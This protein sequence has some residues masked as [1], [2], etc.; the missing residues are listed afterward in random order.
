MI[1]ELGVDILPT[2]EVATL[3]ELAIDVDEERTIVS[4]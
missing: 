4:L 2:E 3:T 1:A